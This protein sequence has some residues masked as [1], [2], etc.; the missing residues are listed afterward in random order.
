MTLTKSVGNLKTGEKAIDF[1]LK[2]INGK[3]YSLNDF[4]D[5]K[6]LL[7]IF[8]CNHCPYVKAK[9][10]M[11]IDLQEKYKDKGLV[12]IGINSNES[13]N[14][15]ED[16]FEGMIETAKEKSF[17]FIYLHDKTQEVAKAYGASCTPDPFLFNA[18]QKL[19]YHG[20]LNNQMEPDQEVT[21]YDMDEAVQAVLDGKK[22]K[23]EFLFSLGC[24]IKWKN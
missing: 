11:I 19:A 1:N 9:Q 24:S 5:A 23:N 8:M 2:G 12:I 4:K 3:T 6:A 15:P 18:E 21:E 16:N 22:P 13:E 10:Q 14:Y 20:R 7:L 17:N